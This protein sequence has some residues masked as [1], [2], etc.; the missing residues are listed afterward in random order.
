MK[1][2][3]VTGPLYWLGWLSTAAMGVCVIAMAVGF[4]V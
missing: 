3:T 1:R 2:F 4:F